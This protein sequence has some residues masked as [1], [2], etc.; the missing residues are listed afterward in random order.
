M[1]VNEMVVK[2]NAPYG[3]RSRFDEYNM[4][5][6]IKKWRYE[7]NSFNKIIKLIKDK[8]GV[9]TSYTALY[10]Y[11]VRHGLN[12]DMSGERERAVNSYQELVD[13][14]EVVTQGLALNQALFEELEKD[15]KEGNLDTKMYT[16]VITS[17]ERLLSRR[18]SLLKTI[19][20][21]Q[22]LIYRYG[23]ISK[24]MD[25]IKDIITE[26]YGLAVWNCI[27]IKCQNDFE[28]RE[29]LK[30]IPKEE[31]SIPVRKNCPKNTGKQS[32]RVGVSL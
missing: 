4:H 1:S 12:G 16:S 11:C 6:D 30:Q 24:F 5:E 20:Q 13:S 22:A 27:L 2:S 23:V 17:N 8:F 14:L 15:A 7:G 32:A 19:T 3:K 18:E 31:G 21:Q 10:T 28:L 9:N 25:R 29:L 26:E